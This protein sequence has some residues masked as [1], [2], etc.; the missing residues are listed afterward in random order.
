MTAVLDAL[1]PLETHT[2]RRGKCSS[3]WLSDAAVAAKLTRR[4]L[5][6]RWKRTG[7]DND[8]VAYRAVC[9]AANDEIHVSRRAYYTQQ[10]AE[11]AGDQRAT[12][13]QAK[14]LLHSDDHSPTTSP[15]DAA[16]LCDEF[17]CFFT[18]KLK[19]KIADTVISLISLLPQH[20]IDSQCIDMNRAC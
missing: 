19:K 11:V 1:P 6:R 8:R 7:T 18:A 4:Q 16:K 14:R 17:S 12:W 15:Q 3:Q 5:E 13:R 2:K 10:L 9:H 20:T